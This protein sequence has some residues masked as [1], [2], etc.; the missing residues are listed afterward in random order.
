MQPPVDELRAMN[1]CN[2]MDSFTVAP[3]AR[4]PFAEL[5]KAAADPRA[6]RLGAAQRLSAAEAG[7]S[8][9]RPGDPSG[10][11]GAATNRR[12]DPA[13]FQHLHLCLGCL[14]PALPVARAEGRGYRREL[15]HRGRTALGPEGVEE[16]VQVG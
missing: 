13:A 16:Q 7:Q 5:A 8:L 3:V 2:W 9:A 4:A 10:G 14:G 6:E 1:R 11:G 15:H 12:A